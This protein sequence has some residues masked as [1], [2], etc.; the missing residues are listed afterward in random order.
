MNRQKQIETLKVKLFILRKGNKLTNT[1][2]VDKLGVPTMTFAGIL[3]G[4]KRKKEIS[5]RFLKSDVI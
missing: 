3:A 2:M 4:M 5:N 1:E